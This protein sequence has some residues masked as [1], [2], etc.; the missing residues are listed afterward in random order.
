MFS[1]SHCCQ[2]PF[3]HRV[4][5]ST[6]PPQDALQHCAGLQTCFR[7]SSDSNLVLLLCSG[8]QCSQLS[9]L[10]RFL[11]WELSMSFYIFHRLRVCLLDCVDYSAACTAGGKVLGLLPQPHC[12]W[13]SICGFIFTSACGSFTEFAPEAVLDDLGLP[14]LGPGVE[15]VQLLGSQGFWQLQVLRGIGSQGSR[16]YSALE[17]YGKQ[18]WPI[19][20]ATALSN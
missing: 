10:V 20:L 1:L 14:L 18:Y 9:E 4:S 6:S 7:D 5:L 16:K 17:G 11:L 8:L 3:P 13:V 2:N 19:V 15:V 12:P